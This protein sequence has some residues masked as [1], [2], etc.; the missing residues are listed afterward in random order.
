M[1]RSSIRND[2]VLVVAVIVNG[3]LNTVPRVL[4]VVKVSPQVAGVDDGGVVGLEQSLISLLD[5]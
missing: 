1:T 3:S 5:D 2:D 4:D